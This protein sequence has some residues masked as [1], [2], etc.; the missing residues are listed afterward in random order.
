MPP[1]YILPLNQGCCTLMSCLLLPALRVKEGRLSRVVTHGF[2]PREDYRCPVNRLT[3]KQSPQ[4]PFYKHVCEHK[5][6]SNELSPKFPDKATL[7]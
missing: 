5:S 3:M 4:Q 7:A 2:K 1:L 6:R